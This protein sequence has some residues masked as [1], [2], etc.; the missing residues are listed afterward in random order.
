MALD[1]IMPLV[2]EVKSYYG[3]VL[4]GER[5]AC[6]ILV[7]RAEQNS[8]DTERKAEREIAFTRDEASQGLDRMRQELI[9]QESHAEQQRCADVERF[10]L[11]LQKLETE[12][13]RIIA[14]E[15][16]LNLEK[17]CRRVEFEADDR[18][19][20]AMEEKELQ[21][22][23]A[24]RRV[25]EVQAEMEASLTRARQDLERMEAR[26]KK[27]VQRAQQEAQQQIQ[28]VRAHCERQLEQGRTQVVLAQEESREWLVSYRSSPSS[29]PR[30][31]RPTSQGKPK[32]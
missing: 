7:K 1:P 16:I 15:K 13:E 9:E 29:S 32:V 2:E 3:D 12:E 20:K 21:V 22:R 24:N 26:M 8:K 28:Q 17:H 30:T 27:E 31:S 11:E 6:N 23:L 18:V 19:R 5:R 25:E 14:T 4:E 10:S